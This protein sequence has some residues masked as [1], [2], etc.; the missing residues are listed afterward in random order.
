MS[1][2]DAPLGDGALLRLCTLRIESGGTGFVSLAYHVCT[3]DVIM[4]HFLF[5]AAVLTSDS[6]TGAHRICWLNFTKSFKF[7]QNWNCSCPTP[8]IF[9]YS[10]MVILGFVLIIM[11]I[12]IHYHFS[13]FLCSPRLH[14]FNQ[15]YSKNSNII[16]FKVIYWNILKKV[17][18]FCDFEFSA[19]LL[20]SLVSHERSRNHSHKL[21]CCSRRLKTDMLF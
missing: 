12:F 17:M 11:T 14:L 21:I 3:C 13:S 2:W 16:V 5:M 18:Y 8:R 19:S 9:E 6:Y 7:P 4:H 1:N 20:R 15:K 10:I